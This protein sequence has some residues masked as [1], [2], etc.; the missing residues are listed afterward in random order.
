MLKRKLKKLIRDPKLFISDMMINN[1]KK[2]STHN[3][4]VTQGHYSYT[5]VSAVYN[6][7][8][9]LDDYFKS[10]VKQNLNFQKNIKLILVDDGSVDNSASV[11]KKWQAKYPQNIQYIYKENGGQASAR[12]V[13]LENVNTDWVTFI[14]SDDF[15]SQN[16]FSSVD[17]LLSENKNL[18]MVCCNQIY[19]FEEDNTYID[20]HPL[21]YRFKNNKTILPLNDLGRHMQFSAPLAFF[22]V[23]SI[24]KNLRFD[25]T[26]KPTFE[27]GK[28]VAHYILANQS[29]YICFYETP[30]YYNRKR[31]DKS[32]TMDNAWFNKG[33]YSVVL[34][35]GYI[36]T[37]QNYLEQLGHIPKFMQRTI[38]W[39][40]LRLIKHL[41][42]QEH[43]V[44]FLSQQEKDKFLSL[45]DK[46]FSYIESQTIL[47]FE[48]GSCGF[49]RQVGML[50]C[51]KKEAPETQVVYIEK[52][53]A[54]KKLLLVRYFTCKKSL[55]QFELNSEDII[56][57]YEK[58][59]S[60]KF[61]SRDFLL[62]KRMW[63]PIDNIGNGLLSIKIDG[64]PTSINYFGKKHKGKV[65]I[66]D[67]KKQKIS[68]KEI[69][70]FMDRDDSAGDNAEYLYDYCQK[71][72]DKEIY[73]I[74]SK[75]SSDWDR[76]NSRGFNLIDHNSNAHK[77]LLTKCTKAISSHVGPLIN[78]FTDIKVNY[79]NIFLQH[80]VTKDDISN[81]INNCS[82][83]LMIT[84][85][86]NE[87]NEI[88]KNNSPYIYGE[89]E[90]KKTG[91][92][93]F[94]SL[95]ESNNYSGKKKILIMPTWRKSISG[96]FVT[97]GSS[98]RVLNEDFLETNYAKAIN[99]LLTNKNLNELAKKYNFEI[100]F[101]PHPNMRPYLNHFK[102]TDAI[103]LATA[104]D[105][106]HQLLK[107]SSYLITDYSSVA[108]DFAYMKK[109]LCYYQF[110]E[111]SFFSGEHTYG[112]GYYNY[113][114]HGFGPVISTEH[115]L[116]EEI[117]KIAKNNFCKIDE[118][119]IS[120]I[121]STFETVDTNNCER[122]LNAILDMEVPH[123]NVNTDI[124]EEFAEQA[125]L[126]KNWS[127]AIV[128]WNNLYEIGTVLQQKVSSLKLIE[129][130]RESGRINDAILEL[131]KL[132]SS[133]FPGLV[134]EFYIEKAKILMACHQWDQ[135]LEAW[136]K[137]DTNLP[138]IKHLYLKCLSETKN[139]LKLRNIE[140]TF[141]NI[142]SNSLYN[143]FIAR[144]HMS[145]GNWNN[146]IETI[147]SSINLFT[148]R[149]ILEFKPDLILSR[150][151]REVGDLDEAH[152]QLIKYESYA[153]NDIQHRFEIAQLA[154]CNNHWSKVTSQFD[155]I[156]ID[157]E[158]LPLELNLIYTQSLRHTGQNIK[159]LQLLD[160]FTHNYD[161]TAE[162]RIERAEILSYLQEWDSAASNWIHLIGISDNA[163]FK[164]AQAYRMMGMIEEGLQLLL[165]EDGRTPSS[166]DE[167]QLR[168]ELSQLT[169]NWSEAEYCWSS[170]LRFYPSS[171]PDNC[172]NSL[173]NA[174]LM[175]AISIADNKTKTA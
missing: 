90:V 71:N 78:S 7:G 61:L 13:G 153:K 14:D 132:D 154:Y 74:L 142:D 93:R 19:Y 124:L 159:A 6:S 140:G 56:P 80:G 72:T 104:E 39:E 67:L 16:Y 147:K 170:I 89:K 48:L 97:K 125:T 84:A 107:E 128:R 55:E 101:C 114:E 47:S 81:W 112:K 88:I 37:L 163:H 172:W 4:K 86:D 34:E 120:I 66:S 83:D 150:C 43:N 23:N 44:S 156:G 26:L 60:R 54:N 139:T 133:E 168:A 73:F 121:S 111:D 105:S 50:G 64:K 15:L 100:V 130:L 49:S 171:A 3:K 20:R 98:E 166:L 119:Y 82:I 52:F 18:K 9:Y 164:L 8:L 69:W 10:F 57:A 148:P 76:L 1:A 106:I 27:D 115:D 95:L 5:V 165:S 158:F 135:A 24:P 17:E 109:P 151:Y 173:Y 129:S 63:L 116:I 75:K 174:Q 126:N 175:N 157:N 40:M 30:R 146:A 79:S 35:N 45:M 31:S 41:V 22:N 58:I 96:V 99:S 138:S 103:K 59:T 32:S 117:E 51:F 85:T 167:W 2:R 42:N 33:Q 38:L 118:K 77:E 161:N 12:N 122:V 127:L 92:P 144:C 70:L 113:R 102:H 155:K 28:F 152:N 94:D 137:V 145:S 36:P 169:S 65:N 91:F 134:N 162:L 123:N 141:E 131:A 29:S 110:D 160:R 143:L 21:N 62:E 68:D 149:E 11:I 53:D 87:H 25:E 108:F 136:S 46:T